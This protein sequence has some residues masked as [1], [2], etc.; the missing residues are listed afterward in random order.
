MELARA[1]GFMSVTGAREDAKM[2]SVRLSTRVPHGWRR[3]VAPIGGSYSQRIHDALQPVAAEGEI[4]DAAIFH[5]QSGKLR[6]VDVLYANGWIVKWTCA[7]GEDDGVVEER[8]PTMRFH[9]TDEAPDICAIE[10]IAQSTTLS[11]A[12]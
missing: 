5:D 4:I 6:R 1:S 11:E 7:A 12:Q 9:I 8:G 2:P 3:S 10:D